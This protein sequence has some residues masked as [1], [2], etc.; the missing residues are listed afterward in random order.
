[1]CAVALVS[2]HHISYTHSNKKISGG[3]LKKK[4]DVDSK[5]SVIHKDGGGGGGG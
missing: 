1:M 5:M 4:P 3:Y 2:L